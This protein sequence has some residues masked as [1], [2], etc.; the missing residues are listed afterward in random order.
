MNSREK[1]TVNKNQNHSR[2]KPFTADTEEQATSVT[3]EIF[4]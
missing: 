1:Q 4:K 2:I 3:A